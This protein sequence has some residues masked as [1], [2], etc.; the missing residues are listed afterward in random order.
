MSDGSEL[1]NTFRSKMV[2]LVAR[3]TNRYL[4]AES[5]IQ[6]SHPRLY[7]DGGVSKDIQRKCLWKTAMSVENGGVCMK[8][9]AIE[10]C[11]D[12]QHLVPLFEAH[13]NPWFCIKLP[14]I[15]KQCRRLRT[16]GSSRRRAHTGYK[17]AQE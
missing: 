5:E 10:H 3:L 16:S 6:E 1:A 2:R 4:R 15:V 13:R 8:A 14:A 9:L 11:M 7:R 12:P 17:A